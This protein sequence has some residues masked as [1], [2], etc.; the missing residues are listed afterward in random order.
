MIKKIALV[1]NV[2]SLY[3]FIFLVWG[4][5]RLLFRLPEGIEEIVLKPIIWLGPLIWF[6][7][8]EKASLSSIGWS[9]K[10]FFRN[11][12]F[13]LGLGLFFAI[14]GVL[15]H[16]VKYQGLSFAQLPSL[17]SPELLFV[18]LGISFIT[19][20]SEETVFRGYLFNR[21]WQ[22][23]GD[24]WLANIIS[25][26]A[27]TFIHLPIALFVFHYGPSQTLIFLCLTFIFGVGSAFV[28]ARTGAVVASVL[29]HVFWGWP[30][31]LF[32]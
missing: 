22:T 2:V 27:W 32:R 24:E 8:K 13:G 10:N 16:L 21:L 29:L 6:L 30:I 3:V 17:V 1:K 26:F 14:L 25:S 7:F 31:L 12:Y 5:Y 28:F 11:L 4:L 9:T 15:T 18:S 23:L 19:A 20:I